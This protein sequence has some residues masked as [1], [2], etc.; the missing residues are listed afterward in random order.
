LFGA[1]D[2]LDSIVVTE[3]DLWE[4]LSQ[5]DS[6]ADKIKALLATRTLLFVGWD[7]ADETFRQL[8]KE[9][10]RLRTGHPG[11]VYVAH[12]TT[13]VPAERW[14]ERKGVQLLPSSAVSA[15]QAAKEAVASPP[16][17]AAKGAA[18]V[19][20]LPARPYKFLNY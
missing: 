16:S 3:D 11:G 2:T 12:P 20:P 6:V 5:F 19:N 14:L 18:A 7:P 17:K 4:F 13:A 1:L 15:L 10:A 9:I 8:Q